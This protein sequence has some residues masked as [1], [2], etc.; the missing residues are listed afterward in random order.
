MLLEIIGSL[1]AAGLL[2]YTIIDQNAS[3]TDAGKI[4]RVANNCGLTI[5]EKGRKQTIHLLRKSRHAWGSEYVYRIPL[6][7]SFDDVQRKKSHIEDG[8][9]H[10]RGVLDLTLDDFLSLDLKSD[11]LTQIR[12]LLTSTKHKKEIIMEYDGTLKIKVYHDPMP[13]R[14]NFHSGKDWKVCVGVSREGLVYHDFEMIPHMVV[15]GMTRYGKSVFL[16][17]VITSLISQPVTF[18]LVDLK[19]GLAFNRFVSASKVD[20]VASDVSETLTALRGISDALKLKQKELLKM[21][22]EDV[23]ES[24]D[25]S[26]HF[27]IID[28]GAEIASQGETNAER[29]K[30][31][32]ECEQ[33]LGEIARIGGALGYRLIFA[34]QY[35]TADTLPRQVKQNA[36][37]RLCF[38]LPTE[39]ASR[40]VLDDSGAESLPLIK[41]R[42]I[43]RTDRV[44]IVQTPYVEN[45]YIDEA[46][47]PYIVIKPRKEEHAKPRERREHS[48]IIEET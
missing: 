9:N 44:T 35:P 23:K 43:Y 1:G 34:T 6:G 11:I 20:M 17:N 45:N 12:K 10:K 7:L 18:T 47:R 24:N 40:V 8:L 25:R 30:M 38:R 3:L 16:K 41:G 2:T 37:A 14:V 4:Q 48:L 13:E 21:K 5:S 26:R 39:T 31:K 32:I 28:E 33:I 46:I 29:K 15:A 22:K 42:A 36:D 19:G 27:I